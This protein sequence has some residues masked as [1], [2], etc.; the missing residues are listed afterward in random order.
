MTIH[1]AYGIQYPIGRQLLETTD[2]GGQ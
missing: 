2:S 1:E